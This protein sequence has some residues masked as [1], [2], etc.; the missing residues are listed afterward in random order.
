MREV[1]GRE[2]GQVPESDQPKLWRQRRRVQLVRVPAPLHKL[3]GHRRR[4]VAMF[5][6]C[7]EFKGV[8]Q[9]NSY[10]SGCSAVP[11]REAGG[12]L[13][14]LPVSA[15]AAPRIEPHRRGYV[16]TNHCIIH[17]RSRGAA[18]G[19]CGRVG[20][21]RPARRRG[22]E[23]RRRRRRGGQAGRW[24]LHMRWVYVSYLDF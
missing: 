3:K 17:A 14:C 11:A 10:G 5:G 15:P 22:V 2:P 13:D 6:S 21:L 4:H 1:G 18:E 19:V 16:Y 7:D 9:Y 12:R 24:A 8:E 20:G 23:E